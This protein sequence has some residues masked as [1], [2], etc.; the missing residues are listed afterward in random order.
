MGELSSAIHQGC[1]L[2]VNWTNGYGEL[3]LHAPLGTTNVRVE[4]RLGF[5]FS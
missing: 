5:E 3:N 4:Q 2:S 1:Q